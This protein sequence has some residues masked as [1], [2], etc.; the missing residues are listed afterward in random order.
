MPVAEDV[1][2]VEKRQIADQPEIKTLFVGHRLPDQS[3]N[4]PVDTESA[5]VANAV[6]RV[7]QL[8]H[9]HVAQ[10]IEHG[11]VQRRLRRQ[12]LCQNAGNE[13]V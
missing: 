11:Q 12:F 10:R 9:V 5:D 4:R 13:T 1:H 6:D 7:V 2:V 3:R 8:I